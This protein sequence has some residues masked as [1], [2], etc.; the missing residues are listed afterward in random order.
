MTDLSDLLERAAGRAHVGPPPIDAILTRT[1]RVRRIRTALVAASASAAVL[2]AVAAGLAPGRGTPH[3]DLAPAGVPAP[4]APTTTAS[5][6][7]TSASLEG[8]W[9]VRALVGRDGRSTLPAAYAHDV[10]LAFHRGR[11]SGTTGCN[12]VFGRYVRS[13]HDLRFSAGLGTTDKKCPG[14]PPLIARLTVV[15]RVSGSGSTRY[16]HAA[17]GMIV[18]ELRATEPV[19]THGDL[20]DREF[21]FALRLVRREVHH[22]HADLTSATVTVGPGTVTEPNR[23]SACTSGR[24]LHLKLIGTFPHTVAGGLD[25]RDT[26]APPPD[27]T[28]HAVLLT[29]D[30]RTGRPCLEG[31]QTG[32]VTPDRGAVPLPLG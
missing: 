12:A 20:T 11:M 4:P 30:A 10:E 16:L 29:A 6:P 25:H 5:T 19:G 22:A 28:V 18:A 26:S 32:H 24:L 1:R 15:R 8:T 3:R 7:A 13:G 9:V 21:A 23:G 2:I 27:L 14:E 17:D 31:V